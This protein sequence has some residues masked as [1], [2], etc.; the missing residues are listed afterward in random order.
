[1]LTVDAGVAGVDFLLRHS[2]L[3]ACVDGMSEARSATRDHVASYWW[4]GVQRV[5][6]TDSDVRRG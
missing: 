3:G 2:F 4:N 5:R 1:M 6:L